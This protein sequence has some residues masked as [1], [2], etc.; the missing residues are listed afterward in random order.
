M[1]KILIVDDEA[2]M[3]RILSLILQEEGHEVVDAEG[4]T[5][6]LARL[7][8][9]SFDLVITDKK[10]VDGD[11]FGVLAACR[12]ADP[13]L[14]V[15]MLTAFGT[16]ELAVEA[17]Q[18]GAFDFSQA[19]RRRGRKGCRATRHGRVKLFPRQ[20]DPARRGAPLRFCRRD[21]GD[22]DVIRELKE[23]IARV[24]PTNATVLI[25]GETGTGKELAAEAI[26][27]GV[28][29]RTR[30]SWPS[31]ARRLRNSFSKS[32][33]FGHERIIHRCRPHKT[34]IVRSRPSRDALSRRSRRDVFEFAGKTAACPDRR[35]IDPRRRDVAAIR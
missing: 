30:I 25:T 27:R 23:R 26:H 35:P 13:S 15:V 16:I 14:P 3:R 17:M 21:L 8:E 20:R 1:A 32:E 33:L 18:S 12:E 5:T 4:L 24:A 29:E 31:T 28:C 10:L 34:G 11:G 9:G 6:A 22:S 2:S 7:G 19:I